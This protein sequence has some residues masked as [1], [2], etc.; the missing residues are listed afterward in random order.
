MP[1]SGN[2]A[3]FE[4]HQFPQTIPEPDDIEIGRPAPWAA[5]A[6]E[7]RRGITLELVVERL[8]AAERHLDQWPIPGEPLEMEAVADARRQPVIQR[9][10][11]LVALFEEGGEAQIVL[12][13]R[14]LQLRFHRGEVA[15]PGGRSDGDESPI[16]TALR[17]A[18]EEVGIAE[19]SVTP[20]GWLNPI[21]TFA[22]GSAIWPVVG[23]LDGRP[24][25]V[26]DP[27]E[28]DRAFAVPLTDLLSDGVYLQE[29][30]RRTQARPGADVDG[31]FPMYFY[32]VPGDVVWGATA[33]VLTELLSVVTDVEWP[34]AQRV[35][36]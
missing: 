17:E 20:V 5:L 12:T 14:S 11:V 2:P 16:A 15:L 33:R 1:L 29:R 30:W 34:D 7:R 4:G 36:A 6:P 13:R 23:L 31:Y 3:R 26:I 22:S 19:E 25:M 9:S 8:R 35:W 24:E 21:V 10:A 28:V 18:R 27:T 32:A